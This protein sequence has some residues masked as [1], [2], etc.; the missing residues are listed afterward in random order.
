MPREGMPREID[1]PLVVPLPGPPPSPPT[2]PPSR[3]FPA[4]YPA[5]SSARQLAALD[6]AL[7]TGPQAPVRLVTG[8]LPAVGSGPSGSYP[9]AM[10]PHSQPPTSVLDPA[11]VAAR[12]AAVPLR[13]VILSAILLAIAVVGFGVWLV[14]GVISL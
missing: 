6:P 9:V 1:T 12:A 11:L 5:P 3:Q 7:I 4:Q 2:P 14:F 13:Y 8:P 10:A